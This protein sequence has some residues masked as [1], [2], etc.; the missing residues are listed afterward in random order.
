MP[1]RIENLRENMIK[2]A[3]AELLAHGYDALAIRS[4]AQG[5]GI[6]VGTVY[7]YFPS[8]DMLVA[9]VMLEDWLTTLER[10]RARCRRAAS[11]RGALTAL[12]EG[13][14]AFSNIYRSVWA[15]YSFSASAR[16]EFGERH[17][18]LVRQLADCVK[19]ALQRFGADETPGMDVFLA[20]NILICDSNSEMTFELLLRIATRILA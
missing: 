17:N 4:V 11:L 20:E 18:L 10:M 15:G 9:A 19:P 13:V 5:C 12:Y 16:S 2:C 3:K 14:T 6:A 7:N 1:K 8:K